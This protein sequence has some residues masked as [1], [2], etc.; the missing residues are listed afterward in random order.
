MLRRFARGDQRLRFCFQRIECGAADVLTRELDSLQLHQRRGRIALIGGGPRRPQRSLRSADMLLTP[1]FVSGAPLG[2]GLLFN[3]L[4]EGRRH[5]GVRRPVIFQPGDGLG[6]FA[7]LGVAARAGD[8]IVCGLL[9]SAVALRDRLA[10]VGSQ[11]EC[12]PMPGRL[13]Q[14]PFDLLRRL[15]QFS[16]VEIGTSAADAIPR[17]LGPLDVG[18]KDGRVWMVGIALA[19]ACQTGRRGVQVVCGQRGACILKM[20]Q[21]LRDAR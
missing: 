8:R 19:R 13:R 4:G 5:G 15:L 3:D 2:G 9:E 18:G 6:V 12:I 20:Q 1:A 7:A 11:L 10:H 14:H 21:L 16:A 17:D